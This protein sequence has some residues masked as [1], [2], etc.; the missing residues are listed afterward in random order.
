MNG[1]EYFTIKFDGPSTRDHEMDVESLAKSLLAF[2]SM[3]IKL[4][5]CV[6]IY[7]HDADISVKVK[8]GVVEG[9]VDVKMVIDFVGA[10]LPLMHE[11]IP[12]LTMIKDFISLRKFLKGSQPKET[13]DQ[14]EG[15]MSII[16][17]DGASMV[18]NA[19]VFQV[20]GNVHIASD[21]AHFMD[22]LNHN[23]IESI[24]IIGTNNDNNPL[25]V[26]ANDK[27]AFSLVPGEILEETVSNRELEFMTIQMD[28]NRKGWR[29]YDSENDV[30]FAAIIADD[31]FLSNVSTGKYSF[32][33][34]DMIEVIM[35][36][37][38]KQGV[39]RKL[40]E[41]IVEKVNDF[42]KK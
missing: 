1:K 16:N 33:N 17:G 36:E 8:G 5:Q 35:R 30:E 39:Q 13:I 3:T 22:P 6:C 27:D 18:I 9:S 10:T 23:D 31:E 41:R 42:I 26:T 24:S 40:T 38:K 14:G 37:I 15:K 28:G 29:F 19:P 20:Y 12:L 7:G 11:A 2:K 25:V 4:N 21:L 32:K 34:G